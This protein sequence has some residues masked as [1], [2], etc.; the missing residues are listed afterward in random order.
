MDN[1][2]FR[3]SNHPLFCSHSYGLEKKQI[4]YASF[5]HQKEIQY[6]KINVIFLKLILHQ[7]KS[8]QDVIYVIDNILNSGGFNHFQVTDKK[9]LLIFNRSHLTLATTQ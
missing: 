3:I 8:T 7:A 2:V 1:C 9:R 4:S 6:S 5:I